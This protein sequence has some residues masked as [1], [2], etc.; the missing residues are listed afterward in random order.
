MMT[1]DLANCPKCKY[2]KALTH[3]DSSSLVNW[4]ACPKCR[5]YFEFGKEIATEHE[6]GFWKHVEHDTGFKG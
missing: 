6:D 3:Y 4:V 2:T 1:E 5:T